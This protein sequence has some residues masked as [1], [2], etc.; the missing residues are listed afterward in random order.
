[1]PFD[2]L[3]QS[4]RCPDC[5]DNRYHGAP[6][7]QKLRSIW[8]F[9]GPVREAVHRL[10]Y[11]GQTSLARPLARELYAFLQQTPGTDLPLRRIDLLV[12]VPLFAWRRW[13]RGYNQSTLL[14]RE[15]SLLASIP[16]QE[17]LWR[18]R[19]TMSQVE[20]GAKQR[21][22]NVQNAFVVAETPWNKLKILPQR[23]LVL[24]DVCT[25]GS[26]LAEC[27]RVLRGAGVEEVYG[28]TLAR[29]L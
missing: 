11:S 6:P 16:M 2:P 1:L 21:Q 14:A 3:A 8:Q 17:V 10:K 27:A 29:Q 4:T 7:F 22:K 18:S 13:R 20:L 19:H 12:P 25:T 5:R 15:L 23:V 28:L 26:T 24:D 9:E